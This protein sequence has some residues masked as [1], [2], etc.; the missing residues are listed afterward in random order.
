MITDPST[1]PRR[2]P[3]PP[4]VRSTHPVS[5]SLTRL[6]TVIQTK[7]EMITAKL[8]A[9]IPK[10]SSRGTENPMNTAFFESEGKK[11]NCS[12]AQRLPNNASITY[13]LTMKDL[14]FNNLD[15]GES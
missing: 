5:L 9:R 10:A 8:T 14:D 12:N 11:A 7:P 4:I 1:N 15:I 13:M 2:S 3:V 6:E